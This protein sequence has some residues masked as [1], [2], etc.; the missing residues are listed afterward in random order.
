MASLREI[1]T[2][3]RFAGVSGMLRIARYT[4]WRNRLDLMP[5][6]RSIYGY[7]TRRAWVDDQLVEMQDQSFVIGTTIPRKIR[8]EP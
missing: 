7:D 1:R 2:A 3:L 4:A 8:F 6:W 5:G